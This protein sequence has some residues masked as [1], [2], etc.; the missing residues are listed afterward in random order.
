MKITITLIFCLIAAVYVTYRLHK[1]KYHVVRLFKDGDGTTG[2][3]VIGRFWSVKKACEFAKA[4]EH[5]HYV[6]DTA[7]NILNVSCKRETIKSEDGPY[8]YDT[9]LV[10]FQTVDGSVRGCSYASIEELEALEEVFG[11]SVRKAA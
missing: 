3:C 10:Y 8:D 5:E 11:Y 6:E 2:E 9:Q 7:I 1:K 4:Y